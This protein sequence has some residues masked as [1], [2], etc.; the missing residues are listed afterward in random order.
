MN[1]NPLGKATEYSPYYNPSLLFP[2][3]RASN[4]EKVGIVANR[5]TGY[6]LWNC[7]E[8]SW[9]NPKGK[10]IVRRARIVY[11]ADSMFIIE[12]KSLKLYLGSF[13]MSSFAD[14]NTVQAL[15]QHDLQT[16][17]GA[18]WVE[19]TLLDWHNAIIQS[20]IDPDTLIDDYDVACDRYDL[21]SSLLKVT[22][23][24]DLISR[25]L[26]SNVLKTNCPITGQPDWATVSIDYQGTQILSEESLLKYIVSYREHGDYHEV[27]CEKIFSD[28]LAILLP[29]SLIVKCWFTR[30]GGIDINPCR[31]FGTPADSQYDIRFW[32]Q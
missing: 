15:I 32:R 20:P 28:I 25:R 3:P 18:A 12:S 5:F 9:L 19:V 22:N 17:L 23:A 27:C 6:D 29:Q 8:L 21:D 26:V 30:R 16:V 4:R 1:H 31:F 13:L 2:I 24:T 14:A 7:H 11:P 10:P